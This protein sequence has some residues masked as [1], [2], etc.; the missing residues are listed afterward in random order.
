MAAVGDGSLLERDAELAAAARLVEAAP[1]GEGARVLVIEGPAGIG[2]STVLA[3]ARQLAGA[4]GIRV[5]AARGSELEREF[6]FGVVRQLFESELADPELRVA[7]LA[8]AAAPAAVLFESVE[9]DAPGGADTSFASLHALYWLTLNLAGTDPL[10]LAVDDLHWSDPPTL[11][12]LAYLSRRL[13][14]VPVVLAA[15]VRPDEPG[16]DRSLVAEITA[17]PLATVVRP[18]ALS[19]DAAAALLA[20][21]L[22]AE[23]APGF[24]RACHSTTAGNP[25]LLGELIKGLRDERVEPTD[26]NLDVVDE[27]GPRA[28]SRTVLLRLSRVDPE[29]QRTA[30]AAAVLD[31]GFSLSTLAGLAGVAPDIAAAATGVLAQ[32]EILRREQPLGFVHPLIRAAIYHDIPPGER[33]L[34]HARAARLLADAGAPPEE[35]AAHLLAVPPRAEPWIAATLREAGRRAME[36][37]AADSAVAYFRR[38]LAEPPAEADRPGVLLE[39]GLVESLTSV[40][41]A[42][43]HLRG[44]YERIDDPLVRGLA[45]NALARVLLWTSPTEAADVARQAADETPPELEDVRLSFDAFEAAATAFGISRPRARERLREFRDP[46]AV[47]GLGRKMMAAVASWEWAHGNG[48]REDCGELALAALAGGE[49]IAAD[50]GL[51]PMY[52]IATLIVCDREEVMDAWEQMLGEA[53]RRG[54]LFGISTIDLWRGYTLLRRGD[55]PAAEDLLREA[56]ASFARYGY[57]ESGTAYVHAHLAVL[58]VERGDLDAAAAELAATEDPGGSR[59][60]ARYWLTARMALELAR[61]GSVEVVA[62]AD[63]FASRFTWFENPTDAYWRSAKALALDRL[64]RREEAIALVRHELEAARAWGAPATVGRVLGV[65]GRIDRERALEHLAEAVDLLATATTRLEYAKALCD[66]GTALRLAKEP[67]AAR[68]PLARALELASVCEAA[69]LAGRARTELAAAGARPRREALSGVE[70]LT[71]SERRVADLA[72]AGRTNRE[73][74]QELY[75]TPKTVEVHLSATYRKLEIRGRR[76][77]ANALAA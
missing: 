77:L 20:E 5:L 10:I 27:L 63:D 8:G 28:A 18:G 22:G 42:T 37:G 47:A 68:E 17:D 21:R 3:A 33:E 14:G 56:I 13:E 53:H 23:P 1:S 76:E 45:A 31:E 70:S 69:P 46:A 11:R 51:L 2:K 12:F 44:A 58:L 40:P 52:A 39:L 62:L 54:S 41:D 61:G 25:L 43:E 26:A 16:S 29:A 4:E 32:A 64:G 35:V 57:G 36:K 71:P 49:L 60:A 67:A 6:P 15:A 72:A 24:A 59:D 38:A 7:A 9:A 48:P 66:Y 74:A 30:R 73:I 55:L 19:A 65:L 34:D 75:V 50:N